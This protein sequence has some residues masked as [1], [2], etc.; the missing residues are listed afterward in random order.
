[1]AQDLDAIELNMEIARDNLAATL[2]E[3][4]DRLSPDNLK[5]RAS[6]LVQEALQNQNV[7]IGLGVAAAIVVTIIG[8]KIFK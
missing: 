8:V 2:D 5:E 1:M 4:A 6:E 3:I 7:Q